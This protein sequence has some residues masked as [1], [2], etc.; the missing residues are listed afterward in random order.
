MEYLPPL[1]EPRKALKPTLTNEAAMLNLLLTAEAW[2]G[3]E[4]DVGWG[5]GLGMCIVRP[6][7]SFPGGTPQNCGTLS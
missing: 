6:S 4:P 1:K 5:G 7:D 3:R 2:R